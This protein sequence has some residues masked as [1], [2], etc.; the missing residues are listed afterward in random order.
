MA[1][2]T[3]TGA[4]PPAQLTAEQDHQRMMDLLHISALRRGADGDSRIPADRNLF[5]RW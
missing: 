5:D 1:Q 2:T 4:M 3:G